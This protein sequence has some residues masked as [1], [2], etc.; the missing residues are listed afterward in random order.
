[1]RTSKELH[2]S[3]AAVEERDVDR[4]AT[5]LADDTYNDIHSDDGSWLQQFCGSSTT[6][7]DGH[8]QRPS[9]A[10]TPD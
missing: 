8:R 10:H 9:D 4:P 5:H 1:V 6:A 3:L 7:V 2:T